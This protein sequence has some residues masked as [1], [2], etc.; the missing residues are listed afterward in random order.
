[1]DLKHKE[2][3]P[4][5]VRKDLVKYFAVHI[6]AVVATHPSELLYRVVRVVA[7]FCT[8]TIRMKVIVK[9]TKNKIL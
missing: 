7:K 3:R 6:T 2:T 9:V 1:M 5:I 8:Q 4:G